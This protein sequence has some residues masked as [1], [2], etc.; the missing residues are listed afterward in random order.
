M[1]ILFYTE[2]SNK[3]KGGTRPETPVLSP[4]LFFL[5]LHPGNFTEPLIG[6]GGVLHVP[7]ARGITATRPPSTFTDRPDRPDPQYTQSFRHTEDV[8]RK[9]ILH[10]R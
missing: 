2:E 9:N 7:G 4:F 10:I 5:L 3:G 6:G 8:R 1:T